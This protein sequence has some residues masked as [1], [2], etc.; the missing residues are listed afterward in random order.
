[1]SR[2]V[3]VTVFLFVMLMPEAAMAV[4]RVLSIPLLALVV[5]ALY[6]GLRRHFNYPGAV[7]IDVIHPRS[8]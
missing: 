3:A 1:M 7:F 8:R 5:F 4:L 6:V 2:V